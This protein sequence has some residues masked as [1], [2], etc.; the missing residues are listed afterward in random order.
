MALSVAVIARGVW[1]WSNFA[2]DYARY[3][4]Q[5]TPRHRVALATLVG[6]GLGTLIVLVIGVL[7]G[8]FVNASAFA[9]DPAA[10]IA[11]SVPA[12]ATVPFLV[13]MVLGD[14]TANYLNACSSGMSFLTMGVRIRHHQAVLLDATISTA[15]ILYALFV[16]SGFQ[17]FFTN[18]LSLNIVSSAPEA[19]SSWSTTGSSPVATTARAW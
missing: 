10:T 1:S 14:V 6:G 17:P 5:E 18:F 11:R 7:L 15:I 19:A 3:L 13:V 9:A 8:T 16:S 12:W 4:P 2:S